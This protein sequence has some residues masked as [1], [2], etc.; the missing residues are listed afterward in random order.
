MLSQSDL[1]ML[2]E[3]D[4]KEAAEQLL[5]AERERKPVVQ[6]SK[7][8]P[9]IS[10]DDAYAIQMEVIKQ[11][12]AAGAKVVGHKIGL[13]SKAMQQSSQI[14]EPDY[15]HLL[16]YMMVPDGSKLQHEN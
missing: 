13:T 2:S 4:L 9:Q 15:G 7:T 1:L 16:D 10:I 5:T 8:W 6:L 12:V 3:A 14:D 11:K